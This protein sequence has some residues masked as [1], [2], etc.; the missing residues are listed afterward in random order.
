MA[1]PAPGV[2][3]DRYLDLLR[4]LALVR[5]VTYH[6]FGW[7]WLTL[8]FPSLGVMFA[9]AGSLMAASLERR[10][11]PSVVG[12]RM[13]RLLVPFG[14][15]AAFVVPA[16]VLHGWRPPGDP[17]QAGEWWARL[18]LW[19]VPLDDPPFD[20]WAWQVNEPLWYVRAYLW[21]VLLAPLALPVFRRLP[22]PLIA[23]TMLAVTLLQLRVLDT[24]DSAP[25]GRIV[26]DLTVFGACWLLGFAHHRGQIARLSP[27]TTW[28]LALPAMAFGGWYA[29]THQTQQ[30]YDLGPIPLAQAYW[31]F[32]FVLLL[33]RF[34]PHDL[35]WLRRTRPIDTLVHVFNA[36]AVTI[37]LWHELA[38]I[39][40]VLVIDW[41]WSVPSLAKSLPLQ[42]NWWKYVLT[43]PLLVVAVL[44]F[45][46]VEDLAA[47][48]RPQLWPRGRS[49]N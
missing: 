40:A 12:S 9:L 48:R 2:G 43:W 47:K 32:G 4:A 3:R 35:G 11:A 31:S 16:M 19:V 33:L 14:V 34:R 7:P 21:F 42:T 38:L 46:W 20:Q 36:R 17:S 15:F 5:I 25:L 18:L 24:G 27:R 39:A 1:E 45:G 44:A 28:V 8:L 6:A 29:L 13:R 41:M 22:V 26:T 10:P 37:Y 23:G 49:E 30:A